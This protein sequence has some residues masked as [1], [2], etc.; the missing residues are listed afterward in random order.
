[1]KALSVR[2]P[3]AHRIASGEK[4]I[5]LRSWKPGQWNRTGHRG[6]LLICAAKGSDPGATDDMPRGVAVC[7]VE[8]LDVR[9]ATNADR[10]AACVTREITARDVAWVLR[11]VRRVDPSP[12][13][14]QLGL[15]TF[16]MSG[17]TR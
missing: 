17:E 12:V 10:A 7:I 8:L 16:H 5:E 3:H 9:P 11:L 13:R 1:M 14:G 15:F 6:E 2:Q 4:T